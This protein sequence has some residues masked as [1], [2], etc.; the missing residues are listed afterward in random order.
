MEGSLFDQNEDVLN[1]FLVD[2]SSEI[3]VNRPLGVNK[4]RILSCTILSRNLK[5][6]KTSQKNAFFRSSL[7]IV[8]SKQTSFCGGWF[9]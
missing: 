1:I 9:P 4:H 2:S 3:V 8:T 7:V 5:R 6:Y